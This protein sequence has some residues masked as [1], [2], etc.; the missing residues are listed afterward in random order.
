[1]SASP[2]LDELAVTAVDIRLER[3]E[4][5]VAK[6]RQAV[7]DG[8]VDARSLVGDAVLVIEGQLKQIRKYIPKS[9]DSNGPA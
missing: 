8:R 2:E 3:I 7:V 5:E 6:L 4:T 1:M 9:K